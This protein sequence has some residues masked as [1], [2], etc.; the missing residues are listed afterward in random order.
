MLIVV[1]MSTEPGGSVRP[2]IGVFLAGGAMACCFRRAVDVREAHLLH[3]IEV[4]QVT[5]VFLKALRR[6]Q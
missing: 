5:P 3:R 6:W 2:G 1:F 4:I